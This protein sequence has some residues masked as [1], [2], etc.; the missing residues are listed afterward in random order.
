[1]L[2][3]RR[4]RVEF[5]D[6]QQQ[7]AERIASVC[8]AVWNTGLEQRREYRRRGA[9][10]NYKPQAAELADAKAEHPW[11]AAAARA[12]P[13][14][15]VDGSGQGV[16]HAWHVS[17]AVALGAAVAAVVSVPGGQQDG[18]GEAQPPPRP[19]EA[20]QAGLGASNPTPQRERLESPGFGH[21][22]DV[23]RHA[24]YKAIA[25][26]GSRTSRAVNR[27]ILSSR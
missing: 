11:L 21:G 22:E 8:R 15:D 3:G 7:F 2:T 20:A 24:R 17:G 27:E 18:G 19:G 23:K 5:T 13:A 12:L 16:P 4:F 14:A 1:M 26:P 25:T 10:M 6:E 9:W